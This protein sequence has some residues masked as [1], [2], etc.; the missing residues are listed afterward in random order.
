VVHVDAHIV[1]VDKPAGISTVPFEEENPDARTDTLDGL[2]REVLA[3]REARPG[4]SARRAPLGVVH[5][6]DKPTSGLLVFARTVAAKQHLAQQARHHSMGRVYWAIARG[7]VAAARLE[8][9][10]V[11]DRGDGIR[12]SARPGVREGQHAVTHVRP[13]ERLHGATLVECRLETGRTHQIR[14]HLSEAGHPLLGETVY[15]KGRR[16]KGAKGH[17]EGHG[18]LVAVEVP[19]LMLHAVELELEHPGTGERVQ[20]RREPPPDFQA[21]LDRLRSPA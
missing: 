2:V 5:R 12:G 20:F 4:R 14:I 10:L 13:L 11:A 15:S 21:V 18:D 16:G 3:A 6:L 1:V 19:R 7:A 17:S 8:S 9:W